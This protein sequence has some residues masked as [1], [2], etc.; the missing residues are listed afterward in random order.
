V[1]SAGIGTVLLKYSSV[2]FML[3]VQTSFSGLGA[4]ATVAHIHCCISAGQLTASVATMTPS[5]S[6]FPAGVT[7]GTYDQTFDMSL[8]SSYNP[9]F[10]TANGGTVSAALGVLLAGIAN[11]TAY[12]NIHTTD[13]PAGEIRAPIVVDT[14]FGNGFD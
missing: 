4:G 6:G 8:A 13:H 3:R 12:F 7:A 10:I 9:A 11:G 1:I 14:I 5:F 2:N